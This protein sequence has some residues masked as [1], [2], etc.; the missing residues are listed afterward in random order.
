MLILSQ[1]LDIYVYVDMVLLSAVFVLFVADIRDA[2]G[3]QRSDGESMGIEFSPFL[4]FIHIAAAWIS[5]SSYQSHLVV[6]Y[7]R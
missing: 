3:E 7:N 5:F 1:S 2:D 4:H 6:L